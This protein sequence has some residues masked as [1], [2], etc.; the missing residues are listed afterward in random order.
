MHCNKNLLSLLLLNVVGDA[1]V[2]E[3]VP[4]LVCFVVFMLDQKLHSTYPVIIA[5]L[6]IFFYSWD[7]I[8]LLFLCVQA[9]KQGTIKGFGVFFVF[10]LHIMFE[11]VGYKF[12]LVV[13]GFSCKGFSS[14]NLLVP[15]VAS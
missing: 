2:I 15:F 1:N 5:K 13:S 7:L 3:V 9:M 12:P 10:Y 14:S 11:F 8:N 6:A 4:P